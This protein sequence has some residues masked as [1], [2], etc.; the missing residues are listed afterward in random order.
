MFVKPLDLRILLFLIIMAKMG[1]R[2][3]SLLRCFF[4][5]S[6]Q[7]YKR[8]TWAQKKVFDVVLY[9]TFSVKKEISCQIQLVGRNESVQMT[10]VIDFQML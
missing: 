5:L 2:L 9:E 8:L 10:A 3:S 1:F 7:W 4:L 6:L